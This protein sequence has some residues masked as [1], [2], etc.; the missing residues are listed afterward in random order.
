MFLKIL[1]QILQNFRLGTYMGECLHEKTSPD[2][3]KNMLDALEHIKRGEELAK[4]E[5]IEKA[6]MEF[7]DTRELAPRFVTFYPLP[8][9]PLF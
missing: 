1:I 6:V 9:L 2:L 8:K 7:E 3:P 4:K 5:E